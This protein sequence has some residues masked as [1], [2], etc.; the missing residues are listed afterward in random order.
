MWGGGVRM[1][2]G[3]GMWARW[4]GG[5]EE[6]LG[7]VWG[8]LGVVGLGGWAIG[9]DG[10]DGGECE[11]LGCMVGGWVNGGWV[12]RGGGGWRGETGGGMRYWPGAVEAG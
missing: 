9:R 4:K 5:G 11:E 1:G 8:G 3:R 7:R 12:Y 2:W 10:I 6:E